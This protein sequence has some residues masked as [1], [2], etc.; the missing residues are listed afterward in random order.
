MN[1]RTLLQRYNIFYT[2]Y[3]QAK[4]TH[5]SDGR[6]IDK[7]CKDVIEEDSSIDKAQPFYYL[8][9]TQKERAWQSSLCF[10]YGEAMARKTQHTHR[11]YTTKGYL[12]ELDT[13]IE[14][15]I[16]DISLQDILEDEEHLSS[17]VRR[18][19]YLVPFDK[20]E[21]L[22][23]PE[24]YSL[25]TLWNFEHH[26]EA[27]FLFY[28]GNEF[29]YST[30]KDARIPSSMNYGYSTVIDDEGKYGIIHNKTILLSGDPDFE[31]TLPCE[32]YYIN[33]EGG[34]SEVQRKKPK[35]SDDFRDYLC[36]IIDL[37]TKTVYVSNALCG[38]LKYD[39]V[40]I[41]V[42]I[43]GLLKLAKVDTEAKKIVSESQTYAYIINQGAFDPSPVQNVT[44][45][46]WGYIDK[47]CQEIISPQYDDWN[48]FNDGYTVVQKEGRDVAIDDKGNSLIPSV[49]QT[50]KHYREGIFFVQ[51]DKGWAALKGK[52]FLVDFVNPETLL[53]EAFV[54]THLPRYYRE[55][56]GQE[57]LETYLNLETVKKASYVLQCLMKNNKLTLQSQRY[58]LTLQGYLALFDTI[59]IQKD[60]EEAGLWWHP[61]K[62]KKIPTHYEDIIK[63]EDSYIIGWSYPA[64]AS[65]FD[66]TVELPVMF[67]KVDGSSLG[68]GITLEDLVLV[69]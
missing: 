30:H 62:V 63:Q 10:S 12:L 45:K 24:D 21:I 53:D 8:K 7:L 43:K 18:M 9:L 16:V 67:T 3:Q 20:D 6:N 59:T 22:Q 32:Y 44:T 1:L 11:R 58:T 31:W 64:S 41:T 60:L 57:E 38:S 34:L 68:L 49:Y 65:L 4:S 52:H 2:I 5:S 27:E 66:M 48:F 28:D 39:N 37:E 47:K 25:M 51:N 69:K 61:V 46:L 29:L 33:I 42:D 56:I 35:Q 14:A 13:P 40:F 23:M 50:I 54:K 15:E 19:S 26:G 17:L 55:N 36:D